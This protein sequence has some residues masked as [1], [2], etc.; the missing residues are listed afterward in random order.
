MLDWV[1]GYVPLSDWW[2]SR[3]LPLG[4]AVTESGQEYSSDLHERGTKDVAD[5]YAQLISI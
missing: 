1:E 3:V 2:L 4:R 5:Q